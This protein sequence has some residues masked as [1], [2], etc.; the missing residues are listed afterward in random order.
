MLSKQILAAFLNLGVNASFLR[1]RLGTYQPLVVTTFTQIAESLHC[2]VS[3]D[4]LIDRLDRSDTKLT[5]ESA[6]MHPCHFPNQ[7]VV[8]MSMLSC[9]YKF[10]QQRGDFNIFLDRN[11]ALS[12]GMMSVGLVATNIA[13]QIQIRGWTRK[14]WFWPQLSRL[15][16]LMGYG[17]TLHSDF[18]NAKQKI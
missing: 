3:C 6:I 2:V 16:Y 4:D 7:Y 9:I 11:I 13:D 10:Y 5:L 8:I 14:L 1:Y 12:L 18:T 15:I 17:L